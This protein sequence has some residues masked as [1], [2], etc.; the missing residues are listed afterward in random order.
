[1]NALPK[2]VVSATLETPDWLNASVIEMDAVPQLKAR[3]PG[4]IVVYGSAQ[5]VRGL[6]DAGL[7]DELRLFV[8]PVLLGSGEGLFGEATTPTALELDTATIVGSGLLHVT[9]MSTSRD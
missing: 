2:Y 6:L 1:M 7:V 8:F 5:L 9:Y 3:I 4:D